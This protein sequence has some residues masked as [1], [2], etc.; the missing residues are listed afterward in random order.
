ML[1]G[2]MTTEVRPINSS[3]GDYAAARFSDS[4]VRVQPSVL[5]DL[6]DPRHHRSFKPVEQ[7]VV[8]KL[9]DSLAGHLLEGPWCI[10]RSGFAG[11]GR[12]SDHGV[13]LRWCFQA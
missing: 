6:G 8:G 3:G 2:G 11:L 9:I 5:Q 10:E 1:L 4:L 13:E 12:R 7:L